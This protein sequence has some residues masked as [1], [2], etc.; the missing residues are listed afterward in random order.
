MSMEKKKT[1]AAMLVAKAKPSE[2]A[3]PPQE[4][5]GEEENSKAGES[6]L[7]DEAD[8]RMAA[9]EDGHMAAATDIMKALRN[10]DHKMLAETLKNLMEIGR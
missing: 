2:E 1:I 8:H 4:A 10:N 7:E 6:H 3:F 9:D 5:S